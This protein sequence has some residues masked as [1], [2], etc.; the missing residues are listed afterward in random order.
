MRVYLRLAAIFI[1]VAWMVPARPQGVKIG[2]PIRAG[3]G[4]G[5]VNQCRSVAAFDAEKM[6]IPTGKAWDVGACLATVNSIADMVTISTDTSPKRWPN[7][8]L[9][10]AVTGAQL[11]KVVVKFGDDHPEKLHYPAV[12]IVGDAL[13]TAFPCP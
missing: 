7:F 3:H 13:E 6:T 2:T 11:A 8:C 9:P 5:I 4:E 1:S 12:W 10:N